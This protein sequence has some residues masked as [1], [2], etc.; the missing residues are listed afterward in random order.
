MAVVRS[1]GDGEADR[2]AATK[3]C[4]ALYIQLAVDFAV[5]HVVPLVSRSSG[6]K[7]SEGQ[8][9]VGSLLRLDGGSEDG[10]VVLAQHLD[11]ERVV[12]GMFP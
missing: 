5:I 11:P 6:V 9:V 3:S 12:S 7:F 10:A 1:E 4:R 2:F 8:D